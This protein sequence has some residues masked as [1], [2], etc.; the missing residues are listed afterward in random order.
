MSGNKPIYVTQPLLPDLQDFL[1]YLESIWENKILTNGGPFHQR[2]EQALCEY[3][4]VRHICLFTNGTLALMTAL[5]ALRIKGE[6]IT[7]PYSFVATAHSLLWNDIKPVFA[8]IDARTLN[9]DPARIEAAITPHTT[10][11]MPVHCYG[12]PCD[13]EAIQ[14]I[15]DNYDLKVIYD[16]AHAFGVR[17]RGTSVLN[18]GDLS[19]LSFHATKIFNT[20]EGGAIIC[21]DA[22]SKQRI[23]HLK[24]FGFVD[25]VTVVAAGINGKMSEINAA[26]GLLQ[27]KGIDQARQQRQL[28]DAHY[29]QRLAGVAGITCLEQMDAEA[30]NHAYFPILVGPDYPLARD[31]LFQLLREREIYA[32]RYFYPLIS[33]FP[34]YRGMPSAAHANLPVAR[35]AASQVICLPIYPALELATVDAITAVIAR[36]A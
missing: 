23:D 1:P 15:A 33:D 11:I 14:K 19:V 30:A 3:L 28:I 35:L 34:M 18:Y 6:V 4:G 27:L 36:T 26:F 10:A 17:H 12:Q 21:P 24:N 20:F 25:E 7:T 8:D 5:Q 22:K 29:R 16:A 32:R 2:L 31:A 13:V 9:L